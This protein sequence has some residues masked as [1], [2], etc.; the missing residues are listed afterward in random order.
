MRDKEEPKI[1]RIA[2]TKP[3]GQLMRDYFVELAEAA[4]DPGRKVAWCTSVGPAELLRAF[5]FDLYFPENH[6]AMIGSARMAADLIPRANA[7]GYS[8]DICS[9]L[10]SDIGAFLAGVTP[11][12]KVDDR[13]KGVP[14][15]DVL[16][17]NTNQCRDVQDWF[18]WYGRHFDVPVIGVHSYT[19]IG[20]VRDV[21][22]RSIAGQIE[23]LVPHLERVSGR[24]LDIDRL[25]EVVGLSRQCSDLWKEVL[26]TA[27]ARPAPL[28]FFDGTILMGPAVVLRG[29]PRAIAFYELLL[30]ELQG[31]VKA[32]QGAVEDETYRIYWEGMPIWG[33]LRA[34]AELFLENKACVVAS[35]YCNSWIFQD[36]DPRD[37]FTSMA[38]AYTEL[39][40]V[41]NDAHKEKY[42]DNMIELFS[43]DG[44]LFHDAKTCPN[45]SNCRYGMPER[46]VSDKSIPTLVIN[47]DLNDMRLVSDEQ[48]TTNVE[49]FI[50]QLEER[51]AR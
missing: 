28:T 7:L 12:T 51:K 42:I 49:A 20:E 38:Q 18:T 50:E 11:M 32:G 16:V 36:F 19:G 40:I 33:R 6:G 9:Y 35:T 4:G 30:A 46:Y 45:N 24:K 8:P 26:D 29:D 2:A 43:V 41:R 44:I 25:R 13:I 48:M 39:F 37:P 21:H 10:T 1:R 22:V 17:F 15:P 27:S 5:G 31:R 34:N 47:G 14:R 3:M 23:G